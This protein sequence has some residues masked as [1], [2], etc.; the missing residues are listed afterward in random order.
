MR[1]ILRSS[2]LS[3]LLLILCNILPLFILFWYYWPKLILIILTHVSTQTRK[4]RC[5]KNY[6]LGYVQATYLE[7]TSKSRFLHTISL[8]SLRLV[9]LP[10]FLWRCL[11]YEGFPVISDFFSFLLIF[12]FFLF[13]GM[14]C[15]PRLGIWHNRTFF[16]HEP[17]FV[18][19]LH[20]WTLILCT[21]I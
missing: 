3:V 14:D 12:W 10:A 19:L 1:K 15:L 8:V 13:S 16:V 11:R 9:V 7:K 20:Y 21:F 2:T 4:N 6:Y 5:F 17:L 18:L